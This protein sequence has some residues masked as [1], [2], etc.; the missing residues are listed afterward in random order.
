MPSLSSQ[1]LW[2]IRKAY[3]DMRTVADIAAQWRMD[4]AHVAAIIGGPVAKM[5]AHAISAE[6]QE[7]RVIR[8]RP[9]PSRL[10]AKPKI[11]A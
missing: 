3:A 8:Y 2:L 6:A 5:Y 1:D 9:K 11:E 7:A 10:F 4:R